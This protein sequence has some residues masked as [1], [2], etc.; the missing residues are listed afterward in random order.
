VIQFRAEL[1]PDAVA[2]AA[3]A[4][5][6][7]AE[8]SEA[9]AEAFIVELDAALEKIAEAPLSFPPHLH[10]SRRYLLRRFPFGVVFRVKGVIIQIVAV[11]H[12]K[13]RPGYWSER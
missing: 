9:A 11:A 2:E 7:Y 3:I 8:R 5:R 4:R 12:A 10:E 1:H 13:R 6:W